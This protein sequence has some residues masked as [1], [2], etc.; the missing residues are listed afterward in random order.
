MY[1]MFTSNKETNIVENKYNYIPLQ[2]GYIQADIQISKL[3]CTGKMGS[4]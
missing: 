2:C 1:E 4:E 3:K